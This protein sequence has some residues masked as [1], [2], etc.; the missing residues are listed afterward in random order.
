MY[1]HTQTQRGTTGYGRNETG[2]LQGRFNRHNLS[3]AVGPP[4]GIELGIARNMKTTWG[5]MVSPIQ[6]S[7][8]NM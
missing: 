8:R 7:A 2:H 6:R 5:S 4:V 1:I 3:G